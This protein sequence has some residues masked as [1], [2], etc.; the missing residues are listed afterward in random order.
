MGKYLG[1]FIAAV[2]IGPGGI[3]LLVFSY[4]FQVMFQSVP[5]AM[6]PLIRTFV[7][8]F[9]WA[10]LIIAIVGGIFLIIGLVKYRNRYDEY[11][12]Y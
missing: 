10:G 11:K 12:G 3:V 8:G 7:F 4:V 5:S 2:A 9:F 6:E 1:Y